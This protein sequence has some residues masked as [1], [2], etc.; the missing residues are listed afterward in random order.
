MDERPVPRRA[1][2]ARGAGALA[3][4]CGL[5]GCVEEVGEQFPPN[6]RWPTSEYAPDL[7]VGGRSA[8]VE[9]GIEAF[10]SETIEDESGFEGALESHGVAVESVER[11]L[12]ALTIEYETTDLGEGGK[13]HDVGPIAGAYAALVRSGYD[14]AFLEVTILDTESSSFGAAEVDTEW[15][16]KYVAGEYTVGEYGELVAGTVESQRHPPDVG[17]T[18]EE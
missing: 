7:P 16:R 8:V 4:V 13:L 6:R 9:E 3:A 12:S 15:A 2:L 10:A 11:K 1:L 17:A 14:A 18:P 5:S